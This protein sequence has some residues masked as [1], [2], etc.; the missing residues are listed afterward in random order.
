MSGN[1]DLDL[2]AILAEFHGQEEQARPVKRPEPP[3]AMS[4]RELREA[5]E[6]QTAAEQ[7]VPPEEKTVLFEPLPAERPAP[8]PHTAAAAP[9]PAPAKERRT[10]EEPRRKAP[11]APARDAAEKPTKQR[12][13]ARPQTKKEQRPGTAF[14]LMFLVL[15]LLAAALTGL[16]HWS[17]LAEE[18]AKPQPPQEIRMSLG[19]DLEALLNEEAA[20][21][22]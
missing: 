18:A 21:S 4:R 7:P 8:K 17:R 10:A 3:K 9:A 19:E 6:R 20:S 22:R 1:Q 13:A 16:M 15:L 12:P 5:A 14:A 2:D 11:A